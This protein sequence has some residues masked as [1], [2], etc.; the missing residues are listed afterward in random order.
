MTPIPSFPQIQSADLEEGECRVCM[1]MLIAMMCDVMED[2]VL[3]AR[4][5]LVR[6]V[7]AGVGNEK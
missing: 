3:S 4:G 6:A 1:N 2:R 5:R 7:M